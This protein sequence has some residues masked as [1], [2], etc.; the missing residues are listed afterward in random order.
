MQ[1]INFNKCKGFGNEKKATRISNFR[2]PIADF[3]VH[4]SSVP[5]TLISERTFTAGRP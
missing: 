4:S 1:F 3:D 5:G 2:L